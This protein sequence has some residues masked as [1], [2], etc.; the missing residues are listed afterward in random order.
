MNLQP[1]ALVRSAELDGE[2]AQLTR[3]YASG[4]FVSA[5]G[6]EMPGTRVAGLPLR[7]YQGLMVLRS[8]K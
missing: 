5:S 4:S 6:T 7:I 1:R 8:I 3:G 2:A